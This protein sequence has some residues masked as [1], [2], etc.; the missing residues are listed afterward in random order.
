MIKFS[1]LKKDLGKNALYRFVPM[2]QNSLQSLINSTLYFS[3]P[4][5]QNDP[6][7]S[8]YILDIGSFPLEYFS[9]RIKGEDLELITKEFLKA[10]IDDELKDHFGICCFS[11]IYNNILLWSH[12]SQGA[13]G[14][15]FVFD[16]VQLMENLEHQNDTMNLKEVHYDKIPVIRPLL[17]DE[18]VIIDYENIVFN[19]IRQWNY[20][21]EVR[22]LCNLQEDRMSEKIREY[23]YQPKSL[24]AILI[25]ERMKSVDIFTIRNIMKL[26]QFKH[27]TL[28][29][30][31]R[32]EYNPN[33][34]I[35]KTLF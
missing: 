18:E 3:D 14:F 20:E 25:G 15:C 11:D 30:K 24:K 9:L 5:F 22:I 26:P 21:S 8:S 16:R 7:D 2:N 4:H 29:K 28:H 13:T 10:K 6:I 27:I 19:K 31:V 35:Y 12:Y 34:F 23:Y 32:Q 17:K 1:K 33:R